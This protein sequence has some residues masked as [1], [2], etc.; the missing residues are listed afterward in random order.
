MIR[1]LYGPNGV[2]VQFGAAHFFIGLGLQGPSFQCGAIFKTTHMAFTILR[3]DNIKHTWH[4]PANKPH[5][6]MLIKK[7]WAE[8]DELEYIRTRFDNV[9]IAHSWCVWH[10]EMAQ[11]I[12]DNL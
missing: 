9:P 2:T 6:D 7:L 5:R 12:Y 3:S 8:G 10:G 1:G 11:F 4:V